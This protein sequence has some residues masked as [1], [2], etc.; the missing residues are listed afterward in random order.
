M[1]RLALLTEPRR[2]RSVMKKLYQ[3][4]PVVSAVAFAVASVPAGAAPPTD[5]DS[6][7]APEP[8]RNGLSWPA[9]RVAV[10]AVDAT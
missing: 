4:P 10:D 8:G 5:P 9:T 6:D 3:L 2:E 7:C 1:P